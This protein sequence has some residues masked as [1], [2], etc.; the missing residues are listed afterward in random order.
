MKTIAGVRLWNLH[1][2]GYRF[3]DIA[4]KLSALQG[5]FLILAS[6][7]ESN[8]TEQYSNSYKDSQNDSDPKIVRERLRKKVEEKRRGNSSTT[9]H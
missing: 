5:D 6:E 9:H 3:C 4:G 1:K 2:Q 8:L 7:L